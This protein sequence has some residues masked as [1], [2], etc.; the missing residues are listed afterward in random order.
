MAT[1]LALLLPACGVSPQVHVAGR[2]QPRAARA[3]DLIQRADVPHD[4][5]AT[6][7]VHASCDRDD[8]DCSELELLRVMREAAAEA[9]ATAFIAPSCGDEQGALAKRSLRCRATMARRRSLGALDGAPVDVAQERRWGVRVGGRAVQVTVRPTGSKRAARFQG[10]V[11]RVW[12]AEESGAALGTVSV[13]CLER[14]Q[15]ADAE[16]ALGQGAAELGAD[17]VAEVRCHERSA[18]RWECTADA[19]TKKQR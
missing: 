4:H 9:G 10:V 1:T 17:A 12:S 14:C 7:T 19:A 8:R 16:R 6:G 11:E 18:G 15:R 3:E 13:E 2:V 5:Q